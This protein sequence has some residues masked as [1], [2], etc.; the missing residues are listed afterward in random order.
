[1]LLFQLLEVVAVLATTVVAQSFA[2]ASPQRNQAVPVGKP[3]TLEL[4]Q[5]VRV[6]S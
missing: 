2:I 3:F 6:P 4:D 1:M 5:P